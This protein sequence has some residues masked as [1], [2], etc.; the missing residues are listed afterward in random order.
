[1]DDRQYRRTE[2]F[3]YDYERNIS[4]LKLY[5]EQL[6]ILQ[7]ASDVHA[8]DYSGRIQAAAGTA[9]PV[10]SY[11]HRLLYLEHRIAVVG[12]QTKPLTLLYTDLQSS[13]NSMSKHY[14]LILRDYY[15][16]GLTVKQILQATHWA[17]STFFSRRY[18]LVCIAA[19][20]LAIDRNI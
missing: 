4:L 7:Q 1:M 17:R 15:I 19:D 11:V 14:L 12:R 9:D 13:S 3:L 16:S 6:S 18:S 20:Y 8:Q 2:K 10:G 5:R